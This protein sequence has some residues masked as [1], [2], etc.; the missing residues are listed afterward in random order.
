MIPLTEAAQRLACSREHLMRLA[1]S[2]QLPGAKI[3]RTWVF[4]P[5]ALEALVRARTPVKLKPAKKGRR[6]NPLVKL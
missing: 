6:R 1:R 2:G 3:G 4:L 5:E